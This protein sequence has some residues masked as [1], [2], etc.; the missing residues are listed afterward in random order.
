MT[1]RSI[2]IVLLYRSEEEATFAK[3]VKS[4]RTHGKKRNDLGKELG[5]ELQDPD[6]H[7]GPLELE[8][9]LRDEVKNLELKKEEKMV[10]VR[11]L[12]KEDEEICAKIEAEPFY[13]SLKFLPTPSEM[14]ALQN[15]VREMRVR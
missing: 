14:T 10:E 3:L 13:V 9:F 7:M 4:I 5:I 8:K 1:G 6:S 11:E 12:R 2:P 15:H